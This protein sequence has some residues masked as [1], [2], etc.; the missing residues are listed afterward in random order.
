[1]KPERLWDYPEAKDG[2]LQ[3]DKYAE[4]ILIAAHAVVLWAVQNIPF[5]FLSLLSLKIKDGFC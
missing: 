2:L 3:L 5:S 4:N 1:M